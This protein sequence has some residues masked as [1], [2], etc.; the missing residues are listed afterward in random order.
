[1]FEWAWLRVLFWM[2]VQECWLPDWKLADEGISSNRFLSV[3]R[4]LSPQ[5]NP[6]STGQF[7]F[8]L[9]AKFKYYIW[10]SERH[11]HTAFLVTYYNCTLEQFPDL[12]PTQTVKV[13]KAWRWMG[14]KIVPS[15]LPWSRWPKNFSSRQEAGCLGLSGKVISGE[16]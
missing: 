9:T 3:T 1:M 12:N 5:W 6:C 15:N 16:W 14:M 7:R 10:N 8:L 13:S 4:T 11:I 2:P